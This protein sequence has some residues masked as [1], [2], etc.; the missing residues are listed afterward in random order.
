MYKTKNSHNTINN[1]RN[2]NNNI[3]VNQQNMTIIEF[4][5]EDTNKLNCNKSTRC[6]A[7]NM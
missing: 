7:C 5:K 1:T 4:D 2:D 3:V 6:E